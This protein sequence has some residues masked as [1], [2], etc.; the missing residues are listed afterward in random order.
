MNNKENISMLI[1][2]FCACFMLVS[3]MLSLHA[4]EKATIAIMHAEKQ[5]RQVERIKDKFY[6]DYSFKKDNR[7]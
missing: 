2:F 1:M 3:V 4:I 7:F 5:Q 6:V